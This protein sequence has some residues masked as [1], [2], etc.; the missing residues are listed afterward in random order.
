ML[1]DLLET[2][3][4]VNTCYISA[5]NM[6]THHIHLNKGVF[7]GHPLYVIFNSTGENGIPPKDEVVLGL[8]ERPYWLAA[9]DFY[10]GGVQT[11]TKGGDSPGSDST[12]GRVRMIEGADGE[13]YLQITCSVIVGGFIYNFRVV[14]ERG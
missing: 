9:D 8:S 4:E 5:Q 2:V 6:T 7:P 11:L 3:L 12:M 14:R 10:A 1:V 13:P